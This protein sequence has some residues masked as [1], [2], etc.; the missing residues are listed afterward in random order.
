VDRSFIRDITKDAN[1][2][3]ITRAVISMAHSLSLRV[4][5][6]GVETNDQYDLLRDYGCD[7]GQGFLFAQPLPAVECEQF[8][9]TFGKGNSVDGHCL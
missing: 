4:I 1:D 7:E 9:T 3:A 2:A 8:I 6:E 5:A